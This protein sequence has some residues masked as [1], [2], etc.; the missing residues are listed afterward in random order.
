MDNTNSRAATPTPADQFQTKMDAQLTKFSELCGKFVF[1]GS[2]AKDGNHIDKY[3]GG[4]YPNL[5]QALRGNKP[6]PLGPVSNVNAMVPELSE[7]E[8]SEI[9]V[10]DIENSTQPRN[11]FVPVLD[12]TEALRRRAKQLKKGGPRIRDIIDRLVD[13]DTL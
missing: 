4:P 7:G 3:A 5:L 2:M 13:L 12:N 8:E 10:T 11:G 6:L 9:D 1:G